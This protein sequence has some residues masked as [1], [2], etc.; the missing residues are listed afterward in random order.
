MMVMMMM[1]RMM[2]DITKAT[3][4]MNSIYEEPGYADP[5]TLKIKISG[6]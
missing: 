5:P 4:R 2:N 6:M 3:H 1:M